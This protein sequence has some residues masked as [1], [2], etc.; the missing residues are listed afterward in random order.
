MKREVLTVGSDPRFTIKR[1]PSGSLTIDRISGGGFP[2]GRHVELYGDYAVGKSYIAYMT[3]VLAQQRGEICA[4]VDAEKV[5][6]ELWFRRLGGNPDDLILFR[7]Q[8][9]EELIEVLML[10]AQADDENPGADIV[11]IDSVASLLTTEE[12]DKAPTDGEDR[13]ASRARM[14]S[15]LLRRVTTVNDQTLFLWTNQVIDKIGGYG[16]VTTPGG[17]ALRFYSSLR[18]EMRTG[19]AEK[20][21]QS[22]VKKGKF[23]K[24][25]RKVGQW[26][27][28]KA[29]KQKTA[30]PSMESMYLFDQV[31][32]MVDPEYEIIHLGLEDGLVERSGNT[33]SY[34]DSNGE[35]F[36]GT[37]SRFR[38]LL[39]ENDDLR[40]E[41]VWGIVANTEQLAMGEPLQGG[42]EE[43]G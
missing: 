38:K 23:V 42:D 2:R 33:F 16:G 25:Q 43:D 31:R 9:A 27:N 22:V 10:F 19:E 36:S 12:R 11:V 4:V 41:L 29:E 24:S 5:F 15:R 35:V 7:P 14:M 40:E 20:R 6:E 34:V 28:I 3:M 17:R 26:V 1:V 21:E 13:S 32:R 30:L 18:I 39:A 8:T 37:E